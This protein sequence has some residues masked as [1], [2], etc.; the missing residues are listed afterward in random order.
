[1]FDSNY[2]FVRMELAGVPVDCAL[3]FPDTKKYLRR[4]SSSEAADCA[5][6]VCVSERSFHDWERAGNAIDAFG[7]FCLLCQPCSEA[8]MSSGCGVF[9][10]FALRYRDRAFLISG[11]S[12]AG[13]STHGSI[14]LESYPQEFSVINGD[15]PVLELVNGRIV[16]HPSPWNG[17]EGLRGADAAP[18]AGIFFL[19]RST[20]NAVKPLSKGEM[21]VCAFPAVFQSFETE[22]VIRKAAA[23]TQEIVQRTSGYLFSSQDIAAS[24][25]LLY[26][27]IREAVNDGI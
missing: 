25:T 17:K 13:K 11:G 8:L 1:M 26:Q 5:S 7:E 3:R 22:A 10:A 2:S 23:F 27:A 15:K 19:R 21:A 9:H 6:A 14:L 16:V 20:E 18:L 24:S 4:F 12:G